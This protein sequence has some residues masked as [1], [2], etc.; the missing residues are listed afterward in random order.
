M[1]NA[2]RRVLE[3]FLHPPKRGV[4]GVTGVTRPFV[5]PEKPMVT[6]V[7]PVTYQKQDSPVE[8][9]T[10]VTAAPRTGAETMPSE[11]RI[12]EWLDRNPAPSQA[13]RCAW[14]GQLESESASIVP[15]GTEPGTHAWL[16]GECWRPWQDARRAEAMKALNRIGVLSNAAQSEQT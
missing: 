12:V 4:T 1:S 7:T 3:L 16:H 9:V 5:T 14:C 6:S 13:G 10:N 11:A 15:F 2:A 8:D